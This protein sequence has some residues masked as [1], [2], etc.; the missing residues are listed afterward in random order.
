M[1]A[2]AK[3]GAWVGY[4]LAVVATGGAVLLRWLFDP[5]LGE[6]VPFVTLYAA[7][8]FVAWIGGYRP[9]ILATALGFLAC[10]YLFIEPRG[11]I[12]V[13]DPR[14]IVALLAY[15]TTCA[16]LIAFGE[17]MRVARRRFD[18]LARQQEQ[19]FPQ[20]SAGLGATLQKHSLHTLSVIFFVALLAVLGTGGIMGYM[21]VRRLIADERWVGHS[22]EVMAQL[23]ALQSTVTDAETGQRGYLLTEDE[24]YLEPYESALQRIHGELERA[25][26]LTADDPEQ[27]ARLLALEGTI[28]AKLERL[29]GALALFKGGDHA[30]ALGMVRRNAGHSLM[31]EVREGIARMQAEE[32]RLLQ[33][34]SAASE[35]SY[36]V[37]L[38]AIVLPA[39]LGILLLGAVFHLGGR[40]A[41]QRQRAAAVLAEQR[42]RLR[43]TLESIGDAVI[44]TDI[45]G[46]VKYLNAV[47]EAVTGWTSGD[48]VGQS[49]EAVFR[50][51]NEQT[52]EPVESPVTRALREGAIVGLGNHTILVRKDGAERP[53]DDSAAPIRDGQDEIVGC[54]LI[55]RDIS[56]RRRAEKSL[57]DSRELLRVTLAS[58]GDAVLT[59][60]TE[61]RV[62]Y[63]NAVAESVTGWSVGDA[64]GQPLEVVFRI[65]NEE[66]RRTVESPATRALRE[67]VIVGLANHTVLIRKDGSEL[68]IDDS[69]APIRD[70]QERVVGCVL[71]FRDIAERK[72]AET[73]RREGEERFRLMANSAPVLIWISDTSKACTW[74]N[75]RWLE[76]VGRPMERELG[77]G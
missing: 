46:R 47:A 36:R 53:I 30:G 56:A 13:R 54:V 12:V 68:P 72:Q 58:I 9:A 39:A 34:R 43:V 26:E 4:L 77:N 32:Y 76:F 45:H 8:A 21:R 55:F 42:E 5:V 64:M 74:F 57:W 65:V 1:S 33:E 51:L 22:H 6:F 29:A 59:T 48:A 40:A 41:A 35:G 69:A 60:D 15:L 37:A 67:G 20:A 49:L 31:A 63:L 2:G 11:S 38:V 7:V 61:G 24:E 19:A 27:H 62:T 71:V 23:E 50:I 70:E 28:A 16:I 44:T 14:D 10:D 3:P 25:K 18:M 66:T 17:A 73:A 52:R 75:E